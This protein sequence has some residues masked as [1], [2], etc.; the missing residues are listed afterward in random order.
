MQARRDDAIRAPNGCGRSPTWARRSVHARRDTVLLSLLASKAT[1]A[2]GAGIVGLLAVL[3]TEELDGGD[4]ATG[5]LLGA[6][7]FGVALGPLIA[8]RLIG[9]SLS[10]LLLL[11]GCSGLVFG[12]FYLG[13]SVAPTL[14]IAVPLV[15]PRPP[16]RR[17]A[18]DTVDV[19]PAAARTGPAPRAD[20]RRRLRDGDVDHHAL[21]RRRRRPR[22]RGRAAVGDRRVR[23][24]RPVYGPLYLV[25]TRPVRARLDTEDAT[26]PPQ[27]R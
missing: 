23:H 16:R 20:P 10:R 12:V 19:R 22:R 17:R 27:P 4:G 9:P 15:A 7:G 21:Q 2:I 5:L 26:L 6:R 25:L 8:A 18:V 11:C 3:A 24:P 1:F 14:A 13:L